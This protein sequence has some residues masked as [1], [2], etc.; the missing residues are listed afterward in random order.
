[1]STEA[2]ARI[3][4]VY[5]EYAARW[6]RGHSELYVRW[7]NGVANCPEIL[8]LLASLPTAKQQPNLLLPQHVF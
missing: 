1:M 8:G 4:E 2:T 3:A 5:G 7:A 6:F